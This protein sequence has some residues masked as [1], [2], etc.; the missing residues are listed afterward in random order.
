MSQKGYAVDFSKEK[1]PNQFFSKEKTLLKFWV[2]K[3]Y[4][5]RV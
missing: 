3:D 5:I 1:N 2:S 4:R